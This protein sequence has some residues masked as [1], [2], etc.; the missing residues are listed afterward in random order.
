M[1][2]EA[3][4]QELVLTLPDELNEHGER[5]LWYGSWLVSADGVEG[6]GFYSGRGGET[7]RYVMPTTAVGLRVRRWP[8]EGLE[9]EYADVLDLTRMREL[10]ASDLDFDVTQP[11]SRLPTFDPAPVGLIQEG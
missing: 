8:N 2:E 11:F 7:G 5:M 1:G 3:T 4:V 10:A 6:D 9:P